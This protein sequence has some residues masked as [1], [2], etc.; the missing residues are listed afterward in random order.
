MQRTYQTRLPGDPHRDSLLLAY[1]ALYGRAERMLFAR[2]QAGDPLAALKRDF[3]V[4]FGLT[5]RQFNALAAGVYGKI[6]SVRRRRARLIHS[7]Q[8]RIARAQ[9]VLAKIPAGTNR[10]T[11]SAAGWAGCRSAWAPCE[12]MRPPAA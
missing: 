1:V 7:L 12:P 5:A 8:R 2:L 6:A 10:A 9:H 4:R 11:R 3:L